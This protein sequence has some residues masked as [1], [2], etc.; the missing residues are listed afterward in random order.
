MGSIRFITAV[1]KTALASLIVFTAVFVH[2]Q[3]QAVSPSPQ[4]HNPPA[5]I[6]I[7]GCIQPGA[8]RTT[9]TDSTGTTYLLRHAQTSSQNRAFVEV[10]GQQLSPP[11]RRGEAALPE[12]RVGSMRT[13]SN[14]CPAKIMPPPSNSNPASRTTMPPA[15]WPSESTVAPQ[16]EQA[17]PVINSQGAGGAPSSGTGNTP[18]QQP[19]SPK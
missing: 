19:S 7:R 15:G 12:I 4:V 13:L 8:E 16:P 18:D 3:N 10:R 2:A 6:T 17:A 5:E 1:H 14:I 9:L 11:G